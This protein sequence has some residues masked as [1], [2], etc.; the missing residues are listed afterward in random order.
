MLAISSFCVFSLYF[1]GFITFGEFFS[2]FKTIKQDPDR[3]RENTIY[4]PAHCPLILNR[5]FPDFFI[6]T[7]K[8]FGTLENSIS[9]I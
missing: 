2:Y 8:G 7:G 9:L 1:F 6:K 5:R 3:T 4:Q